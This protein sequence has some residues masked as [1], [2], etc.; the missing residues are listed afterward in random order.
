MAFRCTVKGRFL[1]FALRTSRPMVSE[2]E[3][4]ARDRVLKIMG[5]QRNLSSRPSFEKINEERGV[6]NLDPQLQLYVPLTLQ[7]NTIDSKR[8]FS[9]LLPKKGT[10]YIAYLLVA[11]TNKFREQNKEISVFTVSGSEIECNKILYLHAICVNCGN[12]CAVVVSVASDI[13]RT[14]ESVNC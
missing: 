9:S 4:A 8:R 5:T 12:W 10:S 2:G 7:L 14:G 6:V 1:Y 11:L 3:G 13:Q